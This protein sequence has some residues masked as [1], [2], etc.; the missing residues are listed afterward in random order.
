M[1][2]DQGKA[3]VTGPLGQ[4]MQMFPLRFCKPIYFGP[5]PSRD[6]PAIVNNG[7]ATLV[8]WRDEH[9]AITCWHVIEYFRKRVGEDRRCLFAIS[10]CYF[11]PLAQIVGEARVIDATV[12]RLTRDQAALITRGTTGI[13]S[14]SSSC[15][16]GRHLRPEWIST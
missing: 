5:P 4:E 16:S 9:F 14:S 7:T 11:D 6:A 13:G 2:P 15:S 3:L 8:R 12:L 10:G 1:T